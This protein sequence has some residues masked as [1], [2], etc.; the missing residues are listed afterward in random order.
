[1]PLLLYSLV[2]SGCCVLVFDGGFSVLLSILAGGFMIHPVPAIG[3]WDASAARGCTVASCRFRIG[4]H[5][6]PSILHPQKHL[7]TLQ[8][9]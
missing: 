2:F 4:S 3:Y 1:M 6:F 8:G 9:K 5:P 7:K